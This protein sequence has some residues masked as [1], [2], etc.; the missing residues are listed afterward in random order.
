MPRLPRFS[1]L[2]LMLLPA[3]HAQEAASDFPDFPHPPSLT[4]QHDSG[5]V[6]GSFTFD[7][8]RP[9]ASDIGHIETAPLQGQRRVLRYAPT[10]GTPPLGVYQLQ[11]Y[12][13]KK[14]A[15]AGYTVEKTGAVGEVNE[16]FRLKK[17]DGS[18]VWVELDPD[19]A[20]TQLVILQTSGPTGISEAAAT[21]VVADHPPVAPAPAPAP[22]PAPNP[23]P[24]VTPKPTPAPAPVPPTAEDDALYV[25]LMKDG[26]VPLYFDF[27]SAKA[28]LNADAQPLLDRVT[29]MLQKHPELNLTIVGHTDSYGDAGYNLDLSQQRA[30]AVRHMLIDAG[31]NHKRLTATGVGGTQPLP[32]NKEITKADEAKDRRIELVVRTAGN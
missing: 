2:L 20:G 27:L 4:L 22:S 13:E 1:L 8:A 28:D 5:T 12:Y 19:M 30:R 7:L 14:A 23:A 25:A 18:E 21:P 15:A 6:A 9:T 17:P 31:I 16:T 26:H 29:R 10:P 24:E 32:G 3:L 11:L